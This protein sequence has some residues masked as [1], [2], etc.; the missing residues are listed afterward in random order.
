MLFFFNLVLVKE[1]G[2][3]NIEIKENV[4]IYVVRL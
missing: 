1:R 4:G 2:V 3:K